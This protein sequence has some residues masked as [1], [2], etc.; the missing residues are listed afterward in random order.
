MLLEQVDEWDKLTLFLSGEKWDNFS[1]GKIFFDFAY[2]FPTI[3][4]IIHEYSTFL[5]YFS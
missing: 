4:V 2:K 5:I 1:K 3:P